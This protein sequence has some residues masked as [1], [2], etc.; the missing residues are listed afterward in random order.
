MAAL[1]VDALHRVGVGLGHDAGACAHAEACV[2]FLSPLSAYDLLNARAGGAALDA[3]GSAARLW[4]TLYELLLAAGRGALSSAR[5]QQTREALGTAWRAVLGAEAQ[6]AACAR[7]R[8][9]ADA[10]DAE[11]VVCPALK[12]CI[13]AC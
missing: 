8:A 1:L 4:R 13:E 11:Q 12:R 5:A 2:S 7:V 3:G 9:D 6:K 10:L